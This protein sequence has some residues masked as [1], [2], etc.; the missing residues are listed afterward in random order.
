MIYKN[1]MEL[2]DDIMKHLQYTD[3]GFMGIHFV[4]KF[5]NGYGASIIP[6]YMT[7]YDNDPDELA[8]WELA[9]IKFNGEDWELNYNTP[10]TDDVEICYN[11]KEVETLL[12]R[13]KELE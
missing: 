8:N 13:I 6:H 11:D 3:N 1:N 12:R 5:E 4:F 2:P 9:V 7:P 10:I